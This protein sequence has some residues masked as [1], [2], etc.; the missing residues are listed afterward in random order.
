MPTLCVP[1]RMNALLALD[2]PMVKNTPVPILAITF[3]YV[4]IFVSKRD[5]SLMKDQVE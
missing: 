5:G 4:K 1:K 3:A 2:T